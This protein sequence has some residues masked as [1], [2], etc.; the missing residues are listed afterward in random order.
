MSELVDVDVLIESFS[1]EMST[2]QSIEA[3][4]APVEVGSVRYRLF[5]VPATCAE[6]ASRDGIPAEL[7]CTSLFAS[8]KSG[9]LSEEG[10]PPAVADASIR[11]NVIQGS[12]VGVGSGVGGGGSGCGVGFGS[13]AGFGFGAGLASGSGVSTGGS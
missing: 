12:T 11:S 7:S 10:R 8:S 4:A 13:G 3:L 1:R 5:S 2:A 6:A 9:G